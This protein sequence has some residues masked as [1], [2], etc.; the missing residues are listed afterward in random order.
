MEI[1][2]R[3]EAAVPVVESTDGSNRFPFPYEQDQWDLSYRATTAVS[4]SGSTVNFSAFPPSWKSAVKAFIA[5]AI[6]GGNLSNSWVQ[7]TMSWLRLLMRLVVAQQAPGVGPTAMDA[8]DARRVEDYVRTHG[9]V[10]GRRAIQIMA[11]FADF[12]RSR[13]QGQ[14]QT[15]RPDPHVAAPERPVKTYSDGWE[16]VIPD[17]V[18]AA[19]LRAVQ[20]R[21][22]VLRTENRP[23]QGGRLRNE[24][25][26]LAVV[27]LLLFSGR[28][29]S[30]ILLLPRDCLRLLTGSEQEA[31][32]PGV[33][34]VHHN[35]KTG[36]GIADA[37]I[38]APAADLVDTAVARIREITQPLADAS[39]LDRLFLTNARAGPH[40][41]GT[42]RPLTARA[43]TTWLNGRMTED[44]DVLRPGFIHRANIRYQGAYY[45]VDPHQARHTLAHKAYL[46][47]AGYAQVSD[48]LG[49]RRSRAGLNPM[50][51]VYVHGEARA[52]QQILE[53]ADAGKLIGHAA[54]LVENRRAVVALEPKDVAIYQ[55]QGLLVLPTHYGHC[56]LPASAARASA[57]IRVGSVP[58]GMGVTMRSTRPRVV[59]HWKKTARC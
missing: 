6:L 50:T 18:S 33:W 48:H 11:Q 54:P 2:N 46:G 32:G 27:V 25:S 56:C 1:P 31:V 17:E 21:W 5:D 16:R 34:L 43:F 4:R 3:P 38:P 28:R 45:P 36:S 14:P 37:F 39:S 55:D 57:A 7:G 8:A 40:D 19:L 47:G 15:F 13:H 59:H 10:R 26:Y 42:I 49:H 24:E 44:G 53:Y 20:Q 30:E 29:I 52:V 58:M 12:L 23:V 9:I 41:T 35:T 22:S 51:G